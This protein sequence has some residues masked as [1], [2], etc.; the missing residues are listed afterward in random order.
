LQEAKKKEKEKDLKK[1]VLGWTSWTP[2]LS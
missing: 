2:L 1:W